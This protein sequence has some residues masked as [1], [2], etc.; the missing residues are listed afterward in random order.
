MACRAL[1]DD[2]QQKQ[3]HREHEPI[4]SPFGASPPMQGIGAVLDF[5]NENSERFKDEVWEQ[6]PEEEK[7]FGLEGTG[8]D[9]G[10]LAPET[11]LA[12]RLR[13]ITTLSNPLHTPL[14]PRMKR[15]YIRLKRWSQRWWTWTV[16][17]TSGWRTSGGG[18]SKF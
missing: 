16:A 11:T 10:R 14:F 15:Y 9:Y 1:E 5:D 6:L 12:G 3:D 13:S 18:E 2:D 17:T 8:L 4:F 7:D